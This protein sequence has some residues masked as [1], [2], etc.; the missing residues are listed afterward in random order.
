MG[1]VQGMNKVFGLECDECSVP[2]PKSMLISFEC[3]GFSKFN[4]RYCVSCYQKIAK[5][6]G[7]CDDCGDEFPKEHLYKTVAG[8]KTVLCLRCLNKEEEDED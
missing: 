5:N 1:L 6:F 8:H 7:F 4:G 3:V 2:F